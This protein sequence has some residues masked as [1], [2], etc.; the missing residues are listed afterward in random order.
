[1]ENYQR[2]LICGTFFVAEKNEQ[3]DLVICSVCE[4]KKYRRC[5][6]CGE[7]ISVESEDKI[8]CTKCN[9]KYLDCDSDINL[10]LE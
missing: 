10:Y 8:E 4:F 2:C 3:A 6:V 9:S 7:Y 5:F 1:M